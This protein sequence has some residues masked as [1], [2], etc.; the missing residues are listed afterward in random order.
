LFKKIARKVLL[1]KEIRHV[2]GTLYEINGCSG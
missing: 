2:R 1:D